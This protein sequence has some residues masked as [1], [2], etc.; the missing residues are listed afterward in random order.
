MQLRNC[1]VLCGT[2]QQQFGVV[3]GR[4]QV[5]SKL[6]GLHRDRVNKHKHMKHVSL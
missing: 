4:R 6:A 1:E 3:K 5:V 2:K